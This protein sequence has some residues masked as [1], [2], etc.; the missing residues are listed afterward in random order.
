[1]TRFDA[2][3]RPL[4]LGREVDVHLY[5]SGSVELGD[6][7]VVALTIHP[8]ALGRRVATV[9]RQMAAL[10]PAR[11]ES[12]EKGLEPSRGTHSRRAML[13]LLRVDLDCRGP[14]REKLMSNGR[15]YNL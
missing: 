5:V 13:L 2:D 15:V 11:L 8:P 10:D 6:D 4:A 3:A 7:Y 12:M 9:E 1:V 14:V